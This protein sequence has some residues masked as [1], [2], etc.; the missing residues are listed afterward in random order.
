MQAKRKEKTSAYLFLLPNSLTFISLFAGFYATTLL[1]STS[2]YHHRHFVY[3]S[4]ALL[5]AAFLNLL[6]SRIIRFPESQS[7][8]ALHLD[9]LVDFVSFGIAP[10][11]LLYKWSLY[12]F[13]W[14]GIAVSFA[15]AACAIYRL[16]R[17]KLPRANNS[18]IKK[19]TLYFVGLPVPLASGMLISVIVFLE[20]NPLFI[21][22]PVVI[23]GLSILLSFLMVSNIRFKT[24]KYIRTGPLFILVSFALSGVLLISIWS[25]G[26]ASALLILFAGY[27]FSNILGEFGSYCYRRFKAIR[28]A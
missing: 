14:I 27:M 28:L 25:Y 5:I 7:E 10:A 8:F 12:Q 17:F 15:F 6:D 11:I 9:S 21:A 3:V 18:T 20:T 16:A 19:R 26:Y 4:F 1:T 13:G 24:F 23:L 2:H 22:P